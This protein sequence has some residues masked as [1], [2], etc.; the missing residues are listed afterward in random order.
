MAFTSEGRA[1]TPA[2]SS[3]LPPVSVVRNASVSARIFSVLMTRPRSAVAGSDRRSRS[4]VDGRSSSRRWPRSGRSRASWCCYAGWRSGRNTSPVR[5]SRPSSRRVRRRSARRA[6]NEPSEHESGHQRAAL[7]HLAPAAILV[8]LHLGGV[9][10]LRVIRINADRR[11][12]AV[13][14]CSGEQRVLVVEA[15][16]LDEL[17]ELGVAH[18]GAHRRRPLWP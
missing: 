10:A 13:A 1:L 2:V 6:S 18:L 7:A 4:A 11:A 5:A 16:D 3:T 15:L 14:D 17:G 8:R 12:D 9:V